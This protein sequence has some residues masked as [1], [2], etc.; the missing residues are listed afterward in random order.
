MKKKVDTNIHSLRLKRLKK[1]G[2]L[3]A[4]G[5]LLGLLTYSIL[6][7]NSFS[8]FHTVALEIVAPFQQ[9]VVRSVLF[10]RELE[11][12][13]GELVDAREEN[14]ILRRELQ[15]YRKK[16]LL[17][18]EDRITNIRLA[19][20]LELKRSIPAP[21]LT[22]RIIGKDPTRWHQTLLVDRGSVD[23]IRKGMAAIAEDGIAGQVIAVSPHYAK[24]LLATSPNSAIEVIIQK[25][26]TR[27]ILKG[28]GDQK[29]YALEYVL[30]NVD[31][32]TGDL[33]LTSSSDNSYPEGIVAGRVVSV[34]DSSRGI[35]HEVEVTPSVNFSTL[36]KLLV[37]LGGG[38]PPEKITR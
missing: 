3:L 1:A 14:I 37:V 19:E 18:L 9:A 15:K 20:L 22:A 35:F 2:L 21:T 17:W 13:Y 11:R 34:L 10:F 8:S 7:K 24:I 26:R 16:E 27:G 32:K 4:T 36:E 12:S 31:I 30:K 38:V 5:S 33:I 28:Q 25:N 6:E 23:G 29:P